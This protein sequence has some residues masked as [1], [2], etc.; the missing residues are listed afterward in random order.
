MVIPIQTKSQY[1][2]ENVLVFKF[3]ICDIV[4]DKELFYIMTRGLDKVEATRLIIKAK[5][6][7][8]ISSLF[9]EE[10]KN[11]ILEN[12]DRKIKWNH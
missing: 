5:F 1:S 12:I 10:M 6:N 9:D 3:N 8:L 4:D 11:I 2:S 7:K